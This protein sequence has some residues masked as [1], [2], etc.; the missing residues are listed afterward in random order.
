MRRRP[1]GDDGTVLVLVVGLTA[2]LL[3]LVGVVVDVSAA[4]LARRSVSSA[5]DGAAVSGA[6][7]IDLAAYYAD[8]LG[9]GVPLS[10]AAVAA[11]VQAYEDR[12]REEQ[13]D[14]VLRSRVEDGGTVVVTATRTLQLPFRGWLGLD[15]TEVTAE[16]R[17]RA[18]VVE[19]PG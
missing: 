13:P 12:A 19:P 4:A 8:G 6:Q 2:V 18:P 15:S 16:A 1:H 14:L 5:A 9:A 10:E 17:A 7:G 11:R 3:L